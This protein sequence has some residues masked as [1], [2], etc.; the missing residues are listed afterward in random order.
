MQLCDAVFESWVRHHTDHQPRLAPRQ[1]SMMMSQVGAS[2][3]YEAAPARLW[4]CG[5][6]SVRIRLLSFAACENAFQQVALLFPAITPMTVLTYVQGLYHF[7]SGDL[8][9]SDF[10]GIYFVSSRC[11]S[12]AFLT[13]IGIRFTI[14]LRMLIASQ[15]HSLHTFG[16][17]SMGFQTPCSEQTDSVQVLGIP[18]ASSA[19]TTPRVCSTRGCFRSV[20]I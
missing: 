8:S 3:P 15:G 11:S 5:Q 9:T 13:W 7:L 2:S 14:I 4:A 20:P 1:H 10:H 19:R 18:F 17:K 16:A 12:T 6:R